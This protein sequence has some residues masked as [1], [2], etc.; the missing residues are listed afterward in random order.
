MLTKSDNP[1]WYL[2]NYDMDFAE[3]AS[4]CADMNV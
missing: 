4:Y 1:D 2:N 3:T